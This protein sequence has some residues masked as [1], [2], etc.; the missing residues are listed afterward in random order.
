MKLFMNINS[1]RFT[2]DMQKDI[3][4][5]V[6][7]YKDDVEFS[8]KGVAKCEFET[9]MRENG[10]HRNTDGNFQFGEIPISNNDDMS[11]L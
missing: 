1:D 3:L 7:E 11:M 5:T 4:N 9:W 10:F 2:E 8:F 6:K